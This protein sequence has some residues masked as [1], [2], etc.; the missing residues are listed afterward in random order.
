MISI[1]LRDILHHKNDYDD[2][3]DD[4]GGGDDDGDDD[5]VSKGRLDYQSSR[6]RQTC[7]SFP[8][9]DL[10]TSSLPPNSLARDMP[11]SLHRSRAAR[12][13]ISSRALR[14]ERGEGGGGV[15]R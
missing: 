3:D 9:V 10:P 4:D 11:P 13:K 8:A 5:E 15:G 7:P 1:Q 2:D 6:W 12:R 14:H